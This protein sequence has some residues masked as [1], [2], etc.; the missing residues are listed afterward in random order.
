MRKTSRNE[1]KKKKKKKNLHIFNLKREI[2]ISTPNH[3]IKLQLELKLWFFWNH[4]SVKTRIETSYELPLKFKQSGKF[5]RF[6]A[7]D[8]SMEMP[9]KS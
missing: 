4:F 6:N 8:G 1:K 3:C 5:Q 7:I 2:I 9:K